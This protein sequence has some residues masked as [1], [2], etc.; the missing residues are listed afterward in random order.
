[1]PLVQRTYRVSKRADDR[2]IAGFSMGG[3]QAR[4]IGFSR[5]DLFHYIATFSGSFSGTM[6]TET[7]E[8]DF[9][10]VLDDPVLTN[11]ALKL[12]WSACGEDEAR[13]ITQNKQFANLLASKGIRQTFLTIPGGHTWHVWRR[14]LR[15]VLPLLFAK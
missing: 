13:L 2:A 8:A 15:D 14:N 9:A 12:F 5:L 1:V 4:L 10:S 3:N 7:L 6:T 11:G